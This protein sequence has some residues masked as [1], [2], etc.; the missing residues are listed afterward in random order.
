MVNIKRVC[1]FATSASLAGVMSIVTFGCQPKVEV[2]P[3]KSAEEIRI[4][5]SLAHTISFSGETLGVIASWY[6]GEAGNWKA[7]V[8][9]NPGIDPVRLKI[10]QVVLVPR[11]LLVREDPLLKKSIRTGRSDGPSK[12][13]AA[14]I[15]VTAPSP[16][17]TSPKMDTANTAPPPTLAAE[18]PVTPE[19]VG[20]AQPD[21]TAPKSRD[22]LLKELLEEF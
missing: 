21:P 16:A 19:S 4:E 7:I 2:A 1:R 18:E 11:N 14:A 12:P 9:N 22:E 8:E 6:T 10:G 17:E 15:A 5:S 20:Q 3:P 13:G